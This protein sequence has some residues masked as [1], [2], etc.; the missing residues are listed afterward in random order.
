MEGWRD[1]GICLG[2]VMSLLG[3]EMGEARLKEFAQLSSPLD[4]SV[5]KRER[6]GGVA[7][8]I[9]PERKDRMRKA[10]LPS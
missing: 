9:L 5:E 6:G 7:L 2:S 3:K 10:F 8:L 4:Y 1:T